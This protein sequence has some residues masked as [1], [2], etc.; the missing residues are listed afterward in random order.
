MTGYERIRKTLTFSNPERVPR[1]LWVNIDTISRSRADVEFLLSKYPTDT[2]YCQ[3]TFDSALPMHK[4]GSYPGSHID[5][6]GSLWYV[7]EAGFIGEVKKPVLSDLGKLGNFKPPWEVIKK[8]D[9]SYVNKMCES[10]EKFMLSEVTAR[11][12]ERL[13]FLRGSENAYLDIGY[14][15]KEFRKLLEM[16]H[17]F[18]IEDVRSWCASDVDAIFFMDDWGSARKLLINPQT[19]REIFKPLYKDYCEIIHEAKKFAF[20]HTDGNVEPIFGDLVEVGIDAINS[21]LF[22][23]DIETLASKYK[24]KITFW[25][26]MNRQYPS[27]LGVE[28]DIRRDV[29]RLRRALDDG[30]GGVIA[31]CQ[32]GKDNARKEVEAFFKSWLEPMLN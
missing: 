29:M 12:F 26:G 10:S 7:K 1:D 13:Q 16:I 5:E 30:Q 20:F 8:R 9:F 19:W 11:P 21:Q 18:Y 2:A 28:D 17:E 22:S 23:M 25:G 24:G 27:A 3:L 6:W 15:S 4:T 31:Q 14:G 32:W